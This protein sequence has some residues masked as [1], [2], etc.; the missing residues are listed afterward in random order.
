[1]LDAI[2]GRAVNG[3][4]PGAG[5]P[6]QRASNQLAI[7]VATPTRPDQGAAG[8]NA[9][10]ARVLSL[11]GD[12]GLLKVDG[13]TPTRSPAV[14]VVVPLPG[15][16][17]EPGRDDRVRAVNELIGALARQAP[18][19]VAVSA[20]GGAA[21]GSVLASLRRDENLA[22]HV[23]SVDQA[24]TPAGQTAVVLALAERLRSAFASVGDPPT[25]GHYGDGPG[26]DKPLPN[27]AALS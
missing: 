20:E 14:V 5:T 18:A 26:A 10:T 3:A 21:E 25:A 16:A 7:A 24:D 17:G 22:T 9:E 1:V 27:P 19:I 23:S 2:A 4:P 8:P 6:L 15:K 12:A 13:P 11:F